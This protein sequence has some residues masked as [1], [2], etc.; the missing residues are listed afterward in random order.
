[1]FLSASE[2]KGEVESGRMEIDPFLPALLK[3]ASYV[4]RL[5]SKVFK[6]SPAAMPVRV[7]SENA[8]KDHLVSEPLTKGYVL[9][10]GGFFLSATLESVSIPRGIVGI[11]A[12]LSHLA[13]F[14]V[15]I[16][17]N[18]F[19]V[20]PGFGTRKPSSLTLEISSHSPTALELEPG[21]PIC[22]IAFA[23]TDILHDESLAL[24]KSIY[25]E[26]ETPCSPMLYEEFRVVLGEDLK[27]GG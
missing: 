15:S 22:H 8:G 17:L 2:I 7:W 19:W 5:G 14:G 9:P 6:W 24:G 20:S 10:P 21:I 18:S 3:P 16:H 4:L 1:M 13:R 11:L 23:R 25:E 27:A 26:R 12:T